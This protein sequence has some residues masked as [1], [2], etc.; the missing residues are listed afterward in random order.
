MDAPPSA[1]PDQMSAI[2]RDVLAIGN[3]VPEIVVREAPTVGAR[4]M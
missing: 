4:R 1:T 2:G 3:L